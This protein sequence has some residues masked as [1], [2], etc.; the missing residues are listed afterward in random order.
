MS[1]KNCGGLLQ[2]KRTIR[3]FIPHGSHR[4]VRAQPVA[5][6]F[7]NGKGRPSSPGRPTRDEKGADP[8]WPAP[9]LGTENRIIPV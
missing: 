2:E 5:E 7:R 8:Y 1:H 4:F 9:S 6:Q 3:E